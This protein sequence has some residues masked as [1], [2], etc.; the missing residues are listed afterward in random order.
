MRLTKMA[1]QILQINEDFQRRSNENNQDIMIYDFDQVWGSTALGFPGFGGA[2]LTTERTY[3]I[4]DGD[5]AYVY[6]G[7][8]FA[9]QSP[10]TV[11]LMDDVNNQRMAS[12]MESGRYKK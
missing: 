4:I 8:N 6:F 12:V 10:V 2:A 3:V 9:Y 5:T 11:A 1:I 7:G